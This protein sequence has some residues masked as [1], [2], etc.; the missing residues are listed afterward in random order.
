MPLYASRSLYLLGDKK[1]HDEA[2]LARMLAREVEEVAA[3][4]EMIVGGFC[5]GGRIAALVAGHLRESGLPIKLVFM[6]EVFPPRK[7]DVPVAIGMTVSYPNSLFRRFSRPDM[8]LRKLCPAGFQLWMADDVHEEIYQEPVLG[9]EVKK[10]ISLWSDV[11]KIPSSPPMVEVPGVVYRASY[12]CGYSPRWLRANRSV[13]LRVKVTNTSKQT[14][15][16]GEGS[17]LHL[18]HRWLDETGRPGGDPGQ[19]VALPCE[20]PPG[21]TIALKIKITAPAES[22]PRVLEIDMVD[23]GVA[24]FSEKQSQHP[25]KPLQL[26]INIHDQTLLKHLFRPSSAKTSWFQPASSPHSIVNLLR[27]SAP[28]AATGMPTPTWTAPER[29]MNV[30]GA[31]PAC[32]LPTLPTSHYTR[33]TS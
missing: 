26:K 12:T 14:W 3:G 19:S 6:H 16:P 27:K 10:L 25:T 33:N 23:E 7:L 2:A 9:R 21:Q 5:A 24:W 22:G 11:R 32:G 30:I 4:R 28:S 18:G 17:G 31:R 20:V 29:W 1:R 15:L 13:H 8:V